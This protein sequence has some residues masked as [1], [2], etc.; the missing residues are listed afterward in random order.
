LR[1]SCGFCPCFY[2][3]AV[4]H[5]WIYISWSTLVSLEWNSW[6]WCMIILMR[7]WILFHSILLRTFVSIFIKDIGP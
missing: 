2:L 5:S 1:G 6:S 3:Y 7:C 4:L